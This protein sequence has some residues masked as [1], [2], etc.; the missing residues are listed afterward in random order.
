[1]ELAL[2]YQGLIG[3]LDFAAV[4]DHAELLGEVRMCTDSDSQYFNNL[5]C[6]LYR[7]FPR[8]SYFYINA[9]ASLGKSLGMCGNDRELC[10]AEAQIPWSQT[11][12]AAEKHY[13]RSEDCKFTSFIGYEWTGA[14]YSGSNLHRNI[15]FNNSNVPFSPVSFLDAPSRQELW[16]KLDQECSGDCDYVV[17]PHNSNLSNGFMFEEPNQDELLIQNIKRTSY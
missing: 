4:T 10:L 8:L 17:I 12:E 3:H 5:T 6:R 1:M 15:I 16:S 13:D 11:I 7:E 14:V 9:K 2:E